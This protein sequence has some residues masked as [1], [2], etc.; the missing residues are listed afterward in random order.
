MSVAQGG[1]AGEAGR[2][3]PLTAPVTA[4]LPMLLPPEADRGEWDLISGGLALC[5]QPCRTGTYAD[6]TCSLNRDLS[7]LPTAAR[8]Y[9]SFVQNN[10]G[11]F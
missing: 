8:F 11:T 9:Q 2:W 4:P 5:Y 3:P 1:S 7:P 10:A 6:G